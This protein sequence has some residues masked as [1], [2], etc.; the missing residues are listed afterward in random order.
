MPL[1]LFQVAISWGLPEEQRK[2]RLEAREF[3][4]VLPPISCF[5]SNSFSS[6]FQQYK[7]FILDPHFVL[8]AATVCSTV[9][10]SI[11]NQYN[12]PLSEPSPPATRHSLLRGPGVS[13]M[14]LPSSNS[15]YIS[16]SLFISLSPRGDTYSVMPTWSVFAYCILQYPVN[17]NIH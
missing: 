5:I 4:L 8:V 11:H 1:F 12:C 13:S 2:A 9:V 10:H 16:S 6:S 7:F 15:N 14:G 3:L 17:N